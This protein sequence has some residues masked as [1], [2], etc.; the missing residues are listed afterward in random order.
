MDPAKLQKL[1][2]II[3]PEPFDR[4][5]MDDREFVAFQRRQE[6]GTRLSLF[7]LHGCRSCGVLIPKVFEC[8]TE[9][10]WKKE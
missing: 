6:S 1:E 7:R 10:C 4:K 2:D 5:F 8:C 3:N 9:A